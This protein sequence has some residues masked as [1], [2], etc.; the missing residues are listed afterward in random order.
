MAPASLGFVGLSVQISATVL[1][2]SGNGSGGGIGEGRLIVSP[3]LLAA[4][5]RCMLATLALK[6]RLHSSMDVLISLPGSVKQK[7]LHQER[8]H[9]ERTVGR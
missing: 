6:V 7:R 3:S 2:R 5:L 1:G 9:Q 8:R 4:Q